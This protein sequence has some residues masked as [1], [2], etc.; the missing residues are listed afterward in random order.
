MNIFIY[1]FLGHPGQ[2]PTLYKLVFDL[3]ECLVN[4]CSSNN[5][6][7]IIIFVPL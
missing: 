7:S 6:I 4:K 5:I 3:P 2:A 1:I